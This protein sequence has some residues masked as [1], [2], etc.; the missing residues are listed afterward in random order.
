MP[1]MKIYKEFRFDSAHFLPNVPPDHKCANMHGHTYTVEI[2]VEDELDS[3][4]GWVLD[5]NDLRKVVEPLIDQ[6]DHKVLNDIAGLE[7]PTAE[8]IALWFWNQIKPNLNQLVQVVVK[9]NPTNVCIY[10][11]D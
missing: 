7:N 8:H 6:L 11:G 2:H 10:S 4:L 3:K 1:K 5:Y 9:E